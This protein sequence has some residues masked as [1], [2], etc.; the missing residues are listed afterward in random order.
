MKKNKFREK[1]KKVKTFEN[2]REKKEI[3]QEN[4]KEEK[5]ESISLKEVFFG[6]KND[7]K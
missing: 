7:D 1:Y 3:K 2:K 5:I 6:K 4:P